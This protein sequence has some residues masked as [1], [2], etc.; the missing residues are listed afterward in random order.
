M[1]EKRNGKLTKREIVRRIYW[2][3]LMG[4]TDN[5]YSIA[6]IARRIGLDRSKTVQFMNWMRD[7]KSVNFVESG[8]KGHTLTF[9]Y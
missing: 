9:I 5:T 7:H 6:Y 8:T 1:V 2:R 4:V 3:S